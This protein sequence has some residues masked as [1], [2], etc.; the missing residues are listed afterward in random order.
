MVNQSTITNPCSI[1]GK[2]RVVISTLEELIGTSKV[3]TQ[4]MACPDPT[5]QKKLDKQ[6]AAEKL[7]RDNAKMSF[8]RNSF[9]RNKEVSARP[10]KTA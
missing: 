3:V 8:S 1:C 2:Q 4:E 7:K 5:C 6:L 10:V 9:G